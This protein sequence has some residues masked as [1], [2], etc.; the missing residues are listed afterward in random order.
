MIGKS[1]KE[2]RILIGEEDFAL[3]TILTDY[4]EKEGWFVKTAQN[5]LLIC[6]IVDQFQPDIILMYIDLPGRDGITTTSIL[7]RDLTM[8]GEIP[9]F[10]TTAFPNKEQIIKAMNA[11]CTEFILKPYKFDVLMTKIEKYIAAADKKERKESDSFKEKEQEAEI[12]VYS[13]EALKKAFSNAKE[14]K[15][16]DKAVIKNVVN[17]MTELLTDGKDFT[18]GI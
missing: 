3:N 2:R 6:R 1:H 11:G 12:I 10:I 9:I 7:R 15:V 4:F 16:I 13:K 14:G 18:H 5:G 8:R 17:K